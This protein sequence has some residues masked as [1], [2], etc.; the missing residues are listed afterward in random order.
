[1]VATQ[2]EMQYTEQLKTCSH[3]KFVG[4]WPEDNTGFTNACTYSNLCNFPVVPHGS[5]KFFTPKTQ[6]KTA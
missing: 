3:C 2:E 5:C 4:T 1:M 6:E